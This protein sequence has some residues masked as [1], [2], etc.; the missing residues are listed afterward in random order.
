M[1]V[2]V[3]RRNQIVKVLTGNRIGRAA[4]GQNPVQHGAD[5]VHIGPCPLLTVRK[6]L[7]RCGIAVKQLCIKLGIVRTDGGDAEAAQLQFALVRHI[8]RLRAD[9]AVQD[10]CIMQQTQ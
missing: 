4:A 9:A 1:R 3:R 5:A 10:A 6:I 7:L 2:D 8:N